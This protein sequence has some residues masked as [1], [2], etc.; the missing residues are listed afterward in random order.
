MQ[1]LNTGGFTVNT[2]ACISRVL[3][4]VTEMS[5]KNHRRLVLMNHWADLFHLWVVDSIQLEHARSVIK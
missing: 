5:I 4:V 3:A 1:R 2:N